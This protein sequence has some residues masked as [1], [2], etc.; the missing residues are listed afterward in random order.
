MTQALALKRI[1]E[2]AGHEVVAAFMGE[3]PQRPI[4][5]FFRERLAA[6]LH[7]YLS[8]AFVLDRKRKGV[9]PWA[10]FFQSLRRLPR[11]WT[12]ASALHRDLTA[13]RPD[14]LV[15]FYELLGG[16]YTTL[17]RPGIPV[18]AVGHQFLFFHPE[19]PV[20]EGAR[21]QVA[22]ARH[23]TRMNA[24]GATLRL[25]LSF[26]PLP[27]LPQE[28][29]RVVPPL[30][31]EE[32]LTRT[33]GRGR[34]ILA[35]V[36]NPGYGE[37]LD[38]WQ[39]A[40]PEV[41]LHCFWDKAGAP[42][43]YSPRPGITYHRLDDRTFLELLTTCRGF[44]STAGFESVCEAAYMGKPVMVVPTANHVEQRS[45]AMDAQRAGVAVWRDDFDLTAFV[46]ALDR[47][48]PDATESFRSWVRSAPETFI[49][50]LEGVHRGEDPFRIP[51][52]PR[53]ATMRERP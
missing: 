15:N 1:L 22:M 36:L 16:V 37:E 41:D 42:P 19:L 46:S 35:Y 44:T 25:A 32:V 2:D 49:R 50:L 8:P 12:H 33:P 21:F 3:N 51:P 23:F 13:Y 18:V 43:T 52:G 7:T 28:R 27:D 17:Y 24:P 9:K 4:P 11:Y 20:P 38:R 34:H 26:T 48:N 14:L 10:S 6:P 45:N 5:D 30:L 40:H 53:E 39:S 47:W 29:V 31:R